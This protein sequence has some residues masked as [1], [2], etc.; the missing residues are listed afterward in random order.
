MELVEKLGKKFSYNGV[1]YDST[2]T[3]GLYRC[4]MCS[5]LSVIRMTTIKYRKTNL[6]RSCSVKSRKLPDEHIVIRRVLSDMIKRT[7]AK[8]GDK[9]WFDYADISVCKEWLGDYSAFTKW[10]LENGW[11]KGKS[12][13]RIDPKKDYTPE[14]CR[15]ADKYIQGQNKRLISRVN[16]LGYRGVVKTANGRFYASIT[17]FNKHYNLGAFSTALEAA[18][19]YDNYILRHPECH[20]QTNFDNIEGE[21]YEPKSR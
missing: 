18:L 6:C 16:T 10:A 12:I 21:S 7:N 11:E 5:G 1:S 9:N 15:W 2:K 20:H 14:N 17:A 3:M 13:D 4:A 19:V 8:P